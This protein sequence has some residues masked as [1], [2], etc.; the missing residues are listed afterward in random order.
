M[1][2]L[3]DEK[4]GKEGKK[5]RRGCKQ[6]EASHFVMAC[7]SVVVVVWWQLCGVWSRWCMGWRCMVGVLPPYCT[8]LLYPSSENSLQTASL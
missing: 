2:S 6:A 8:V 7:S 4:R 3:D 1:R 5:G